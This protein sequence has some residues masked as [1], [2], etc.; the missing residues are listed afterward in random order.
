MALSN[1]QW[2][3]PPEA[4]LSGP[5]DGYTWN[6]WRG[7][8]KV[9]R[10]C[11]NCY[12]EAMSLRNPAVLGQWGPDAPRSFGSVDNLRLPLRW[13]GKAHA[14]LERRLVFLGSLMDVGEERSDLDWLSWRGVPDG[15]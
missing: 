4:D 7:C 13:Q 6:P 3:R 5:R 8:A 14:A 9:S 12:A 15:R 11:K 2:L 10:G 1:I